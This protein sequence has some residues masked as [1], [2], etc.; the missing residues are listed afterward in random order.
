LLKGDLRLLLFY[1]GTTVA[2]SGIFLKA[3]NSYLFQ[4]TPNP[5]FSSFQAL[6]GDPV[7]SRPPLVRPNKMVSVIQDIPPIHLVIEKVK[8]KPTLL[9]GL[10]V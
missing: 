2:I 5:S 3:T 1:E 8:P 4:I 7:Y 6:K 10:P 9:L